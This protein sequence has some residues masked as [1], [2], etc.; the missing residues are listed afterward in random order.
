M[1][2]QASRIAKHSSIYAVGTLARQLVGFLMLPIYTNYM[3]PSDYGIIGLLSFT[4]ALLEPLLGA[5]LGEAIPK[6]YFEQSDARKRA[7]VINTAL[8]VTGISS[9]VLTIIIF[10]L[11]DN[12]A[13]LLFGNNVYG[14]AVG[15]FGVQILTNAIE[16]YGM[17]F[18][19]LQD[20]PILYITV[21]MLKLVAQLS[22]NIWL[23]VFLKLTV[24]GIVISGT[25]CSAVFALALTG[26]MLRHTA[27]ASWD[28]TL[29][30]R[31]LSFNWPL[32][33][34][35]LAALYIFSANRYYLR[36]FSSLDQIGL[37]ELAAKFASVLPIFVWSSFSQFWEI[38]RFKYYNS[39]NN[40]HPAFSNVF[41]FISTALVLV[42]TGISL[43]SIPV[44]ELMSPQPFHAAAKAVPLLTFAMLFSCLSNFASFS[45]IATEKT[46][47]INRNSYITVLIISVL[48]ILFIPSFGHVGAAGAL[49]LSL[50]AQF[51]I[52][53]SQS[54]KFYDMELRLKP[55]LLIIAIAASVIFITDFI[56]AS[57]PLP[58][59]I[60][61]RAIVY[62]LSLVFLLN[63][64]WSN[65]ATRPYLERF[66]ST[67][68]IKLGRTKAAS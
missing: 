61:T 46:G 40:E 27:Y 41:S 19:R 32:W 21:S 30:K 6:F 13:T 12:A 22:I 11:R 44:I 16:Y 31:M 26:Y 57:M 23:I 37:Y 48:N 3:S 59:S 8:L 17:T 67:I 10:L 20:K 62:L 54:K 50:G 55:L 2:T 63:P 60:V 25:V 68:K 56:T 43:F 38:E 53:N 7:T 35:G 1:N 66:L 34:S 24:M 52:I 47:I 18:I 49:M 28:L 33:F 51:F 29:G 65:P 9:L 14:L 45:L 58:A 64:L 42:A 4:L 36:V 5:R 39:S 15:L